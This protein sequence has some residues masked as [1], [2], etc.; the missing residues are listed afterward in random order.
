LA[1]CKNFL[2]KRFKQK[3]GGKVYFRVCNCVQ[4]GALFAPF[5][6]TRYLLFLVTPY[7]VGVCLLWEHILKRPPSDY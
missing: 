4:K 7:T 5:W 1:M 2:K 3:N 6:K